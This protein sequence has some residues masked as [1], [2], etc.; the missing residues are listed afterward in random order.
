ME[1]SLLAPPTALSYCEF[2][3]LIIL[4]ID[5]SYNFLTV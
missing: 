2:L 4:T 1:G 3:R 5:Q